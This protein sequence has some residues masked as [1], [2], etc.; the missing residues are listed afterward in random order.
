MYGAGV[1]DLVNLAWHEDW[2]HVETA[3]MALCRQTTLFMLQS[4]K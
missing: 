1:K 3:S 4:N 2:R